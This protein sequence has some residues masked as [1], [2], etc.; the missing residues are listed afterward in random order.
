MTIM[1]DNQTQL[2]HD[3]YKKIQKHKK[4]N[5]IFILDSF[6]HSEN[7]GSAFRLAD[8]FNIDEIIILP[9]N[10][11]DYVKLQKT[12]RSC[13]KY[14]KY[15]IVQNPSEALSIVQQYGYTPFNVEITTKSVPLREVDFSFYKGVALI[16]GNERFG[17]Q[18]EFLSNVLSSVHIEMYG[19]NSS[20]NVSTALAI[21]TYHISEHTN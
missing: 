18:Q 9:S 20:I 4:N 16:L 3:E 12:A 8:A 19:V 1:K 10:K 5:I 7:I 17:V 2:V 11:I 21:A 14:V 6:E 13:E 15:T